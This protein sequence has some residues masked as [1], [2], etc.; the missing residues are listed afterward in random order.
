MS[1]Y[2]DYED[3]YYQE[4]AH[5]SKITKLWQLRHNINLAGDMTNFIYTCIFE[6]DNYL[7]KTT[8]IKHIK[9]KIL[10]ILYK[11]YESDVHWSY[12][13]TEISKNLVELANILKK[14]IKV[15]E[16]T[17]TKM[18]KKKVKENWKKVKKLVEV[19]QVKKSYYTDITA[20]EFFERKNIKE[21]ITNI[22]YEW[23]KIK[24]QDAEFKIKKEE[25]QKRYEEKM[26][27]LKE[28]RKTALWVWTR[29]IKIR[30]NK[31][32][33]QWDNIAKLLRL[34]LELEDINIKAKQTIP[35]YRDKVYK[36]KDWHIKEVITFLKEINYDKD[37]WF[38]KDTDLDNEAMVFYFDLP[39]TDEQ[40]SWHT[41]NNNSIIPEEYL[42]IEYKKD[43]IWE[44]EETT[45]ERIL[46][47]IKKLYSKEILKKVLTNKKI[48]L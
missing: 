21:F 17:I 15:K 36:M 29:K 25:R 9:Q 22:E 4:P 40:V 47:S 12:D 1:R 41:Y 35:Y 2:Y 31:L 24:E 48:S 8:N 14:E 3:F 16:E 38:K 42:K 37:Y 6:I 13:I 7:S 46:E 34:L 45:Y 28:L 39:W 10:S 43:W 30:L 11:M 19:K 18:K 33:K 32:A 20:E 23:F 5:I 44:T 26:K 27:K